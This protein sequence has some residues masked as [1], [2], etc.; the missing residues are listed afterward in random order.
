MVPEST[1]GY[2]SSS[3]C[4]GNAYFGWSR[5]CIDPSAECVDDDDF[6]IEV[7]DQCY[8]EGIGEA[9]RPV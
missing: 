6:T 5:T 7:L 9:S 8:F 4:S 1:Y 2:S 3:L